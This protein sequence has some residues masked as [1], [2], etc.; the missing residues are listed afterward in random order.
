[1]EEKLLQKYIFFLINMTFNPDF[2]FPLLKSFR[3]SS[4]HLHYKY[5]IM[6]IRV[7]P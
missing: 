1:M 4:V 5:I 3:Q 6:N 7:A 2:I